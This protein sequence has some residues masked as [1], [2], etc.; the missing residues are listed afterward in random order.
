M[1][2]L[3]FIP[4]DI[5]VPYYHNVMQVRVSFVSG[6]LEQIWDSSPGTQR[7]VDTARV[8]LAQ[9]QTV[10]YEVNKCQ[11]RLFIFRA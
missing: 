9:G 4:E 10:L 8:Q 5:P 2:V 7:R 11:S 1:S 3:M 6:W